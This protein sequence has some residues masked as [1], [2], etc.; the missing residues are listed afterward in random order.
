MAINFSIKPF[1]R[2]DKPVKENNK[3]SIYFLI[4]VDE[5]Q[6]KIPAKKEVAKI[7]WDKSLGRAKKSEPNATALNNALSKSEQEFK[8]YVLKKEMSGRKVAI[9]EIKDH[10][11]GGKQLT[12]YEFF[13][14]VVKVKKLKPGTVKV[15]NNTYTILK[16]FKPTLS[17]HEITPL[18]IRQFHH[19][20]VT[21]RGNE[22]GGT[23]NRHK[24]L[25]CV[26]LEAIKNE[27]IE[28]NPYLGFPLKRSQPKMVYLNLSEVE[29]V[30]ALEI[31]VGKDHLQR[32]KDIFL[33][34]CYTGIRFSDVMDLKWINII[35]GNLDFT[36]NKTGK[37]ISIPLI[38]KATDIIQRYQSKDGPNIFPMISNQKANKSLKVIASLAEIKKYLTFHVARH[39]FSSNLVALDV[40]LY[41]VRDLLG[42]CSIKETEVYAK[43]DRSN[44]VKSIYKLG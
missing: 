39:S 30:E 11:S 21:V 9:Q 15:Y 13:N 44:I 42:H 8:D 37:F 18:F 12:F 3:Y 36:M 1:I 25:K 33:F 10:F 23:Y 27:I 20:L 19:Y 34:S 43:N 29:R 4:R 28:R 35:D 5:K 38:Q 16:Q 14:E 32:I 24:I 17:F 40:Q 6:L 7:H 31:P 41:I 22:I 2:T 26:L